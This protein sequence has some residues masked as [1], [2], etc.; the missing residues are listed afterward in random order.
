MA[1]SSLFHIYLFW[2]IW[3]KLTTFSYV[4]LSFPLILSTPHSSCTLGFSFSFP[5]WFFSVSLSFLSLLPATSTPHTWIL[6]HP[7][8]LIPGEVCG[9]NVWVSPRFTWWSPNTQ[10]DGVWRWAYGWWLEE[11]MRV[12]PPSWDWCPYKKRKTRSPFSAYPKQRG[13][14]PTVSQEIGHHQELNLLAPGSW[15]SDAKTVRNKCCSS[16]PV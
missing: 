3:P 4:V 9:L 16:H 8:F 7:P 14:E 5:D 15:T 6:F 13:H 10:S 12:E 11:G 2:S 1:F